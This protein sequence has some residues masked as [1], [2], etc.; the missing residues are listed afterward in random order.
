MKLFSILPIVLLAVNISSFAM[1]KAKTVLQKP[2]SV[3]K[4]LVFSAISGGT[5]ASVVAAHQN[6]KIKQLV[7][8]Q[9]VLSRKYILAISSDPENE[10]V[11]RN[12]LKSVSDR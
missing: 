11:A 5:T 12:M 4:A 3:A 8:Q 9:R 1:H 2:T 6:E 10:F 7:D